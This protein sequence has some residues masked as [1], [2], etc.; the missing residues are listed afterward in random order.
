MNSLE[1]TVLELL[2]LKDKVEKLNDR[3]AVLNTVTGELSKEVERL[4]QYSWRNCIVIEGIKLHRNETIESLEGKVQSAVI[5][6]LGISKSE[7]D[8]EFD[9]THRIGP[10]RNNN[11]QR[12]IV[13]FKKHSMCE[14]IYAQRKKSKKIKVKPSLTNFRLKTLNSTKE[15]FEK[16]NHVDFIYADI[17]GNLKIRFKNAVHGRFVYTFYD[18]AELSELIF[19]SRTWINL[20]RYFR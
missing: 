9:K 6:D 13:R 4:Q 18:E 19:T 8:S 20:N 16:S 1:Q 12:V 5:E 17:H 15:R 7:Y 10:V 3:N 11:E 14:K 2:P